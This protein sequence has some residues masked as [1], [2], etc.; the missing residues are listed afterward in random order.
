M[1]K[2]YRTFEEWYPSEPKVMPAHLRVVAEMGWHARDAEL[3]AILGQ[4]EALAGKL[5][6]ISSLQDDRGQY[7]LGIKFSWSEL[8][9][10][11][12]SVKKERGLL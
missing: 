8:M 4:F 2:E 10:L 9:T 6:D 1:S 5:W 3:S 7:T 11:I 12:Q